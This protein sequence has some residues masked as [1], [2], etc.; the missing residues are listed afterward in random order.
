[1]AAVLLLVV[2][3]GGRYLRTHS[4]SEAVVAGGVAFVVSFVVSAFLHPYIRCGACK[5]AGRHRGAFFNYAWRPCHVCNGA[6]R[7]QRFTAA[8]LGRGQR[9]T[10]GSTPSPRKNEDHEVLR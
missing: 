8:A 6:G 2:V 4:W 10:S 3:G 7:K 5:G 1:M 9:T